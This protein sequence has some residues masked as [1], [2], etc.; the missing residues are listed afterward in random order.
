M[1]FRSDDDGKNPGD[2]GHEFIRSMNDLRSELREHR[3][4]V[5]KLRKVMEEHG[6]T[7]EE[8][9]DI[10]EQLGKLLTAIAER[11]NVVK[12]LGGLLGGIL[13]RGGRRG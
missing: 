8:N 6:E 10:I 12:G 13:S 7:V 5:A 1:P 9:T 11:I 4:E 2:L 3:A